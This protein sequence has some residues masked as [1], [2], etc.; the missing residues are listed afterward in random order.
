MNQNMKKYLFFGFL[1]IAFVANAQKT[2]KYDSTMKIGKAGYRVFCMNRSNEQNVLNIRPIG[3][4]A[5][6]REVNI[7][8][9][10]K[11][12]AAEIEDLNNDGFPDLVIYLLDNTNKT[13]LFSIVSKEN[14]SLEPIIL[15]DI[16][17]DMQL[18]KGYR[19]NDEFKLVE[20]ILFRKFPIYE[21]DTAIKAP[22]NKARQIMYRVIR[23]DQ[24]GS[25]K[26]KPFKNFEMVV[27]KKQ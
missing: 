3:F 17:N 4:K 5:E 9:R 6:V 8:L 25:W 2:L 26:Y 7:E 13:T 16:M 21:A 18:S 23:S 24:P 14:E 19:G 27:D 22:T 11:V 15:P 12:S 10:A 20:G 1:L